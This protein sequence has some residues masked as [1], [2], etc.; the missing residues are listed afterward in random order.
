MLKKVRFLILASLC[1]FAAAGFAQVSLCSWNIQNFGKSKPDSAIDFMAQQLRSFDV[2]AVV[3]VVAGNGGAQAVARLAAALNRTGAKWD[4]IISDPTVCSPARCERYSDLWKP[5]RVKKV[6]EASLDKNFQLEIEREPYLAQFES[7]GK[8][9]TVACIHALPKKQQPETELKYLHYLPSKYPG[10]TI[11]FCG[12]FNLP[13]SHSVFIPLKTAGYLTA[14]KGQR[15]TLKTKCVGDNCLASEYDN[16]FYDQK[17]IQLVQ[18][19]VIEFYRSFSDVR[20]ARRI[21]DHL[22]VYLKFNLR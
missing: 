19:G 16:F 8:R 10:Q 17:R 18:S 14:F 20:T 12:D 21:S 7:A 9:F 6:G 13:E 15:T 5:S 2:V 4:Y 22:P 3:E 1:L 11:I